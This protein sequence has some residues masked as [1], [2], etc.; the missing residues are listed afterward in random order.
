M[1]RGTTIEVE[2]DRRLPEP[3][4][5]RADLYLRHAPAAFRLAFLLSGDRALA[6][7]LVQDAFVR[8]FGRVLHLR[9]PDAFEPY[10]RQTVEGKRNTRP[11]SWVRS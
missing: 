11:T 10:L 4:S 7:D 8:L 2:T 9:N 3:H 6:D 5:T 1:R